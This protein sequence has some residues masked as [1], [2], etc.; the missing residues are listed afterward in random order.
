MLKAVIF[1]IKRFAIYDG[2]GIRTTIFFKGCSLDCAW[3][4]NPESKLIHPQLFYDRRKCIG[5]NR[6]V[7]VCPAGKISAG[8]RDRF[9]SSKACP[10]G[11][12]RC[13]LECPS[14][15]I[16]K[17]GREYTVDE[18]FDLII[19]DIDFFKTSGG[20]VTFSGGEPLVHIDFV[21]ALIER[22][23]DRDIGVIIETAG[24]VKWAVF[25][26]ILSY[27]LGYY[28]DLKLIDKEEHKKYTGH[29]NKQL[30]DNLVSLHRAENNITVRIPLIPEITDTEEN[31]TGIIGFIKN[32]KLT[33]IPV[34]LLPYN[35]LAE[36]K[37][38]KK[39]INCGSVGPYFR[40]GMK[41]QERG[42]LNKKKKLFT[43]NDINA[44]ILSVD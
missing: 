24:N 33:G 15:A 25:E 26:K 4:Q 40:A 5:C 21:K 36:S 37:F 1:D 6:C 30:L 27:R 39:G 19:K 8:Q 11:C 38:N 35:Q 16:Y 2:P 7:A 23:R 29:S 42:F 13:F 12:E 3:C 17:V 22:L 18:I 43:D 9:D 31:L 20:G 28:Y 41:T 32:N 10:S 34:E 44:R 14:G